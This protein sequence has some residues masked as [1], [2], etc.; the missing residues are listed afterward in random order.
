M[1]SDKIIEKKLTTELN[2]SE[3]NAVLIIKEIKKLSKVM[4]AFFEEWFID[5][6][7]PE[8]DVAGFNFTNLTSKFKKNP[9]EAFIFLNW[10]TIKK[11]RESLAQKLREIGCPQNMIESTL[12]KVEKFQP[13]IT[14]SFNDW[15]KTSNIPDLSIE[16][17]SIN[18][19]IDK[20][21]MNP[22]GAFITLDWLL[23]EPKQAIKA[24]EKGIK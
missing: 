6:K 11:E 20:Y 9:I 17:Y 12:I 5:A 16:G 22:I 23:R 24:L 3:H 21:K 10:I 13:E 2:Y 19:L 14:R 4:Y 18:D 7:I 15:L 1:I 8:I